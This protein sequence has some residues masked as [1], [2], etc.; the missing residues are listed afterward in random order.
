MADSP[1]FELAAEVL[2]RDTSLSALEARGTVRLALKE[3]GLDA[4]SVT[5]DQMTVVAGSVLPRELELRGVSDPDEVCATLEE[6]LAGLETSDPT[7]TPDAI[8]KRLGGR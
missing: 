1:A 2:E 6:K 5:P 7:E 8:F 3:A 4:R